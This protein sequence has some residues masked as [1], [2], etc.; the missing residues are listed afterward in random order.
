MGRQSFRRPGGR[1]NNLPF[2]SGWDRNSIP[3]GAWWRYRPGGHPAGPLPLAGRQPDRVVP[4]RRAHPRPGAARMA[5][6]ETDL[7]DAPASRTHGF[8]RPVETIDTSPT[9][10]DTMKTTTCYMCACRCGI[11]VHL[12]DGRIR[13]IEGNPD[14]PVNHGV[15]C[16]KGSAGIMNHYSPARLH[17]APAAHRRARRRRLPRDRVGGGAGAR[18]QMAGRHPRHASRASWRCSPAA[19][20]A[21]P[22]PAGGPSSSALPTSPHMAASAPSTWRPA[23][24]TPSAAA[25]GS[26]A[27]RTG[28]APNTC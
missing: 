4:R 23:A 20:R 19:T 8:S 2:P 9:I 13:Y 3:A 7:A 1:R 28:S 17:Q 16:G 10:S 26:S 25:S 5:K 6:G 27:S 18:H 24:C 14:H 11:R 21:S 15:L 12:K 22:S